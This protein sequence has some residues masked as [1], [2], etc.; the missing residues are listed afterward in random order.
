MGKRF[1]IWLIYL[2]FVVYSGMEI[3]DL[4]NYRFGDDIGF[5]CYPV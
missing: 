4:L 5:F 3:R 2:V 1:I